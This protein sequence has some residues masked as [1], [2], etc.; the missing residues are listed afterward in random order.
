MRTPL[1]GQLEPMRPRGPQC[2]VDWRYVRA[3]FVGW[4]AD[5]NRIGV[6][7]SS[8]ANTQ[9]TPIAPH[10]IR[11]QAQSAQTIGPIIPRDK[12]WEYAYHISTVIHDEGVYRAWYECVPTDHFSD[13]R[14]RWPI[15]HGNVLCYA[16]SDDG[17]NWRKP[18]LGIAAYHDQPQ[19][20]IVYGRDLS[21]NGLHGVGVFKD[22]HAPSSER[23][24]LIYMGLVTD[25]DAAAWIETHRRR[26][27]DDMDPMCF[28]TGKGQARLLQVS[29]HLDRSRTA[30]PDSD[31]L[32]SQIH[33]MA[34]AVSPDGLHWTPLTEPL[35]VHFSDT[36]NTAN[37]D[38][39]LGRYVGYFRTWRHG[40]RCVGRAETEDYRYWPK[41]PD[42]VLQASLDA[43]PS[44]DVY[45]N[46]KVLYPGSGDTH[47]MFP[48][49]YHRFDDSR[50]VGLASS[51]D[52]INWQ[53][54]PGGQVVR[55]GPPGAWD[56]GDVSASLGLVHLSGDRI[57]VPVTG[58]LHPHKYPRGGEPI[59]APG[60]AVWPKG[61]L[62]ALCCDEQGEFSTPGLFFDGKELSLNAEPR[63][64]G[65]IL[66]E[67][68]DEMGQPI[69]GH[70]FADADPIVA[71]SLDHRVSWHGDANV[72]EYAGKPMS[73]AFRLR[74]AKLFAF[75]F[76]Q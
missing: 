4:Y 54:V 67:L 61:R 45:T 47:L 21:P 46:A 20:N 8:P 28:R 75:E 64:S 66:V 43:H 3:G 48:A 22:P 2:F 50:E 31:T 6:W 23:Y 74:R 56:G 70:T 40:R 60:W 49:I 71:D 63:E 30:S 35:M 51:V 1:A 29:G 42:T 59:G 38:S 11:L 57:A 19:T 9:G 17:F 76:V 25:V 15:G 72:G 73:L 55:R 68:Q 12:P 58:Y 32:P 5:G 26:F 10:G 27:G 37:W 41:T 69:A 7:D 36:L 18:N 24:K 39:A 53:W 34:G 14:P 33:S 65:A 62:S 16:E 13:Q 52:G 44:D